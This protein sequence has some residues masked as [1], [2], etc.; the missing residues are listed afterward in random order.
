MANYNVAFSGLDNVSK[1]IDTVSNN[2]ANAQTVGY[3]AGQWVFADQFMK[4]VSSTD[5]AR[6]G[7]GTQNLSVRRP[8]IQGTITNSANPLDLAISGK[9][10]FRLL[11][12]SGIN[13]GA[14]KVDPAALYYTRNGQFGVNR[15]G[16]IVNENGLYLT[17]YQPSPN[18]SDLGDLYGKTAGRIKMPKANLD[19]NE[20]THSYIGAI[21]DSTGS[22]FTVN[23]NVSFDP[24]Q[25][26]FNNKTTQT[27]FD[28]EGNSHTVEIYYRR[29]SDT[30]MS[31]TSMA[32]GSGYTYSPSKSS[33]PNTLGKTL[34][35]LNANS[36][37]KIDTPALAATVASAASSGTS[38]TLANLPANA[39]AT[40]P[41]LGKRI[42]VN[43]V[44]SGMTVSAITNALPYTVTASGN[45][46]VPNGAQISFYAGNESG[47]AAATTTSSTNL[48]LSAATTNNVTGYRV[49][50]G[51]VDSGATVISGGHTTNL[52]LSKALSV[53]SGAAITFKPNLDMTLETPDGTQ[54]TVQGT[55]NKPNSG[56]NLYTNMAKVEV[57]AS[58]D[59]RFYDYNDPQ[60]ISSRSLLPQTPGV[61]GYRAVSELNFI[62][63]RNID[64]LVLDPVSGNPTFRTETKLSTRVVGAG[65][66]STDVVFDL[67]LTDTTLQAGAFQ[68]TKNTQD[69]APLSRLTNVTIDNQGRIVGVY[70]N[71]KQEFVG[72]VA[73][74]NFDAFEKLIPVGKNA[75]AASVESGTEESAEGVLV[76]RP[77]TGELGEIKSQALESSNVDLSGELV[78]L[79][80][81]Q[82][83]YSANSQ[84]MKAID[85]AMRD[86]LQMVS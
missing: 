37:L 82:R 20:T 66:G 45:V 72:Q 16:Y 62:G 71:G 7:M 44:D 9:G 75:F 30:Q 19:G 29:V 40:P 21:L 22:A 65:G 63:G 4:A 78:H 15:D 74:V 11:Q 24:T 38:I 47:T 80:M 25:N 77:G 85:S 35:T 32:D 60:T 28:N 59:G 34:V 86:T 23:A 6:T 61:L 39:G 36:V 46:V 31:I 27:V 56:E 14:N 18:G 53:A 17:G 41:V 13:S 50:V 12:G 49:Y 57:Y 33:T 67:D 64:S 43:G 26:T 55:T 10:L 3:K 58:I 51:G 2:I 76:G 5:S 70:G 52:V 69:G 84:S 73:L 48:T 54:V 83:T 81:L 68:V 1:A 79:M 8:M 42:F